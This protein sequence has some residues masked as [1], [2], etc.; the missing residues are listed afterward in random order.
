MFQILSLCTRGQISLH[1]NYVQSL[2]QVKASASRRLTYYFPPLVCIF[3]TAQSPRQRHFQKLLPLLL[4]RP[5]RL[6]VPSEQ[7]R[8]ARIVLLKITHAPYIAA[9]WLYEE[10]HTLSSHWQY[11]NSRQQRVRS[12][13]RG[14]HTSMPMPRSK[15]RS[16]SDMSMPKTP[17][18]AKRPTA[19]G[20]SDH[21]LASTLKAMNERLAIMERKIDQLS[22]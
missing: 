5:L 19:L 8:S 17:T 18:S 20:P 14:V 9:I 11:S 1:T 10:L 21:E 13:K 2:K 12:A 4:F 16:K 3:C 6:C 22:T 7:M 15:F